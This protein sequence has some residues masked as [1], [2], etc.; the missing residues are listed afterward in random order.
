MHV[1]LTVCLDFIY[2]TTVWHAL[3]N[4]SLQEKQKL[5]RE[6]LHQKHW[7]Y[8]QWSSTYLPHLSNKKWKSNNAQTL[9]CF[10]FSQYTIFTYYQ[11][12]VTKTIQCVK[13]HYE[14]KKIHTTINIH[15]CITKVN[16]LSLAFVDD[17]DVNIS[18]IV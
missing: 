13:K 6:S 11:L 7:S 8:F 17:D 15:K 3:E 10:I 12:Y 4:M 9:N 18:N 1:T 16:K 5:Q 2:R 14:N